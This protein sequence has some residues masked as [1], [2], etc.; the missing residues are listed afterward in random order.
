MELADG[1]M[2]KAAD[3]R[4]ASTLPFAVLATP[5]D[6]VIGKIEN[7]AGKLNIA[8]VEKLVATEVKTRKTNVDTSLKDAKAKEA[9]GDKDGAIKLFQSVLAQKCMFADKAKDAGKEL[10]RLGVEEKLGE[11]APS[12]NFDPHVTASIVKLMKQGLVAENAGRY[13]LAEQFYSRARTMDF[14]LT[15]HFD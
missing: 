12:P 2:P 13:I 8:D 11:T 9:A 6:T 7:K 14:S 5:E 4:G 3:F 10:K 1:R 15:K